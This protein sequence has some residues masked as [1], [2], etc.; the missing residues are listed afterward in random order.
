M[1]HTWMTFQEFIVKYLS[2]QIPGQDSKSNI[3]CFCEAQNPPK[4]FEFVQFRLV[5]V[6]EAHSHPLTI[7]ICSVRDSQLPP[8]AQ[9]NH[10]SQTPQHDRTLLEL[11]VNHLHL[12]N[13]IYEHIA[14]LLNN[15]EIVGSIA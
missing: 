4:G 2:Q 1:D 13:L 12:G 8:L 9:Q 7:V 3:S 15:L 14:Y 11:I 5:G 6:R 10:N